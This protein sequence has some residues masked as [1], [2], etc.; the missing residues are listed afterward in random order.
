MGALI[1]LA[2][3]LLL[4]PF[5]FSLGEAA[6]YDNTTVLTLLNVTNVAPTISNVLVY[7]NDSLVSGNIILNQ[8][9]TDIVYCNATVTDLNGYLDIIDYNATLFHETTTAG[10]ADQ[11]IDHY[12]NATCMNSTISGNITSINVQ[13]TFNVWFY[14]NNGTWTCNVTAFDGN[15]INHS[16][17]T[18]II[19]P[20]FAL[21]LNTSV[22]DYG[23]LAPGDS[24]ADDVP[25]R[26]TNFGNMDIN[27]S[28]EGYGVTLHDGLA[29]DCILGDI[30]VSYEKYD[31]QPGQTIANMYNLTENPLINGVPGLTIPKNTVDGSNSTNT[32]FWKMHVPYGNPLKGFCNG[33]VLF[34]AIGPV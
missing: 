19:D 9:T 14:A 24:S 33:T 16:S 31:V 30:N 13:C 5:F 22:I 15:S 2:T 1:V 21:D 12:T 23:E 29:M 27:V 3:V 11:N 28:V 25:V 32:T 26:V 7:D 17:G 18:E 6:Y 34:S 4:T 8:G 20:L 10:A